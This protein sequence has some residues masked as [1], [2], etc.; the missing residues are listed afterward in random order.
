MAPSQLLAWSRAQLVSSQTSQ[1]YL[2]LVAIAGGKLHSLYRDDTSY[3]WHGPDPILESYDVTGNP[4]LIIS[5]SGTKENFELVVPNRN[6]GLLHFQRNNDVTPAVWSQ[7]KRFGI[8]LGVVTGAA[9]LHSQSGPYPGA[10]EVIANSG[11]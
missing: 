8:G 2:E 9:L 1:G 5:R 3:S 10:L 4:A 6:G 11:G 7:G